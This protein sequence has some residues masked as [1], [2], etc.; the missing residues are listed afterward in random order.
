MKLTGKFFAV[1]FLSVATVSAACAQTEKKSPAASDAANTM[2]ADVKNDE[3]ITAVVGENE[4]TLQSDDGK[5]RLSSDEQTIDLDLTWRCDFHRLPGGAVRIFPRDFYQAKN[6]RA[7]KKY[8]NT[9][10]VLIEYSKPDPNNAKDC[11]TELQAI[12]IVKGKLVK[13]VKMDNLAAC[14]PFQWDAKN[15]TALFE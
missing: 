10:I 8:R 15:F 11:R 6:K 14:P 5:C 1:V 2:V 12:K 7:P 3:P 9:Q 13:S 4:L